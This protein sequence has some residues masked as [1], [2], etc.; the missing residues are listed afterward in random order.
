MNRECMRPQF[1]S[2][3]SPSDVAMIARHIEAGV[4][5]LPRAPHHRVMV[6]AS[7]ATRS[8]CNQ[9]GRYF[10]RRAGDIDLVPAGEEGGFEAETAFD[11]IEIVLQP[12]LMERVAA[13]LG[14]R[15][16]VSRLDTRHLLR[17]QRIEHLAR[18]LRSDLDAGA[19]SGSLF[20]DSIGAALAVRLLGVDDI[21]VERTNR[22][23]DTQLKRVLEHIEAALHEPLS[24]HRLARVAGASSSHLRTWFKVA[25]GVTLHRYVLRRRVER[26]RALLQQGDLSTSE[27]AELTGFAHQSHLAHW[28]RR[29]IGQTPRDVRRA[30][31]PK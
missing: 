28:M 26:A 29:E 30:R 4:H 13:E 6:H 23:S 25:T 12:A 20:A 31:P 15:A 16:L 27:V 14:G 3:R 17:D 8:Y 22:L 19:P 21:D 11:T 10:V 9:V 18:A 5:R 24:V 7:A 2:A 1:A